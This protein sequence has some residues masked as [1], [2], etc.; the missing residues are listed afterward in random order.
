MTRHQPTQCGLTYYDESLVP[1]KH[2]REQ[3]RERPGDYEQQKKFYSGKK[4]NHT[5]K[6]QFIVLPNGD[7]IVDCTAGVPGPTS[8]IKLFRERQKAFNPSAKV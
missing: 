7:D 1:R 5:L 4:K 6:N 2:A 3:P 8:D